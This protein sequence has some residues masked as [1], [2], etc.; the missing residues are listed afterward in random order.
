MPQLGIFPN[1]SVIYITQVSP[2]NFVKVRMLLGFAQIEI[3][4]FGLLTFPPIS[5]LVFQ[6]PL[7]LSFRL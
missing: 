2:K 6:F 4:P 5:D 7:T 3:S 1:F